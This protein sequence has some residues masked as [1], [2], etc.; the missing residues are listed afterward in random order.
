M[1]GGLEFEPVGAA[2]EFEPEVAPLVGAEDGWGGPETCP[3]GVEA[4][5]GSAVEPVGAGVN[6]TEEDMAENHEGNVSEEGNH[7]TSEDRRV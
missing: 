4:A 2:V 3:E 6:P 1:G 7:S 5:A